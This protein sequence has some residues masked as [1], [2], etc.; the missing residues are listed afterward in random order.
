[1]ASAVVRAPEELPA[2]LGGAVKQLG[3]GGPSLNWLNESLR[4][5]RALSL[6]PSPTVPLVAFLG[7][8]EAIVDPGR[9]RSRVAS[10]PGAELVEFGGARHELLIERPEVRGPILRR[11]LSHFEANRGA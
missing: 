4:E 5:M 6:L 9:I 11:I 3:L 7:G 10:W 8:D 1:M 2:D